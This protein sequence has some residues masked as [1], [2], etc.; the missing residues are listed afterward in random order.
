MCGR[1]TKHIEKGKGLGK[2]AA[3]VISWKRENKET[4]AVEA[5]RE[6]KSPVFGSNKYATKKGLKM[7]RKKEDFAKNIKLKGKGKKM[8][9]LKSFNVKENQKNDFKTKSKLKHDQT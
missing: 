3:C 9:S 1:Y 7:R 5:R 4:A 6:R 8:F 2:G